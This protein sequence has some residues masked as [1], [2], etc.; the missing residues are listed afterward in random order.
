MIS[1]ILKW[2]TAALTT[3]VIVHPK[4]SRPI[5][6]RV[7]TL[8]SLLCVG[9]RDGNVDNDDVRVVRDYRCRAAGQKL[10]DFWFFPTKP[11]HP[12][13]LLHFTIVTC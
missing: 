1:E 4:K 2:D 12:A 3:F 6:K 10:F 11:S 9:W 5:K 7:I 13:M 8:R